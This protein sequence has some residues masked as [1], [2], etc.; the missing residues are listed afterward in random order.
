MHKS[1]AKSSQIFVEPIS[2]A[3]RIP[4]QPCYRSTSQT[5][6]DL[7]ELLSK[8]SSQTLPPLFDKFVLNSWQLISISF[9]L[10]LSTILA[11]GGKSFISFLQIEIGIFFSLFISL[12]YKWE[13]HSYSSWAQPL[14]QP[15]T[16][17]PSSS[18][19]CQPSRPTGPVGLPL[20][21]LRPTRARG[22]DLPSGPA[23]S[24]S[25]PSRDAPAQLAQAQLAISAQPSRAP[26]LP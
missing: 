26:P 20:P 8:F 18:L 13:K 5:P 15:T 6:L 12:K 10:F 17:S 21:C 2:R 1:I 24:P 22:P 11:N 14:N 9:F 16:L 23:P 19:T 3:K 4:S 7:F 25:G